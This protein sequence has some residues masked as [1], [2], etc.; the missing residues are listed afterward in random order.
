MW[1]VSQL[2]PQNFEYSTNMASCAIFFVIEIFWIYKRNWN[3]NWN[4]RFGNV[5]KC[6]ENCDETAKMYQSKCMCR[7]KAYAFAQ[8]QSCKQPHG[9]WKIWNSATKSNN[10]ST[11]RKKAT[12]LFRG[13][14]IK[15]NKQRR[16]SIVLYNY[17]WS[18][19]CCANPSST[20][21]AHN[22]WKQKSTVRR[23]SLLVCKHS[24]A[25]AYFVHTFP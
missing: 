22:R 12:T 7:I 11:D 16:S 24:L 21:T 9:M 15:N 14:D 13:D 6:H 23:F 10:K 18:C 4:V 19:Y 25:L 5:E 2:L 20:Q 8:I 1:N 17:C 3:H